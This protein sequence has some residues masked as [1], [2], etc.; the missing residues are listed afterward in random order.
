MADRIHAVPGLPRWHPNPIVRSVIERIRIHG[1]AVTAVGEHCMVEG[2]D[3][4]DQPDCPFAYTSGLVMHDIPELAVYGLDM[5]TAGRVLNELGNLLHTYDWAKIV[6]A[7]APIPLNALDVPVMLIEIIDKSDLCMS[8]ELFP[9]AP[10]LQ[11][12]WP[13]DLGTYP[14]EV[15]YSL[16]QQSQTIIGIPPTTTGRVVGP[17]TVSTHDGRNRM[18]RRAAQRRR[19]RT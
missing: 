10:A 7:R 16:S 8:N 5:G 19:P 6:D 12:V 4:S 13:D 14:W 18:E 11:V 1:W 2:C 17:R 9:N 3:G 15:G